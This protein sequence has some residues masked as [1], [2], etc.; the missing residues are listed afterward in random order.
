MPPKGQELDDHYFGSIRE[1]IAYMKDVNEEL[2]KLGV[3]AKTQHNEAALAQH[4]LAPIY[5]QCNVAVDHNQLIMEVLKK[6]A[7][8]HG[9]HCLL[10]EK[11]F[12]GVN[13]S[14]KHN[15]WSLTT[16]DGKN[17]LEPGKTPHENIQFLFILMCVLR[18]VDT[19]AELLRESADIRETTT[20]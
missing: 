11:P 13:G 18:A 16:D 1:R 8:R 19:Y 12:A 7:A 14:G 4:E 5:A 17:L 3:S 20:V 9:L 10:H 6:V 2:W 15:N